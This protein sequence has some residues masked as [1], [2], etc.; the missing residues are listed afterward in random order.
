MEDKIATISNL[1]KSFNSNLSPALDNINASFSK[2]KIIGLIGP[3]GAGKTT[4]IRIMTGL[5][6]PTFGNVKILENDT[7]KDANKIY[8]LISYMPQKFGLYEDLTVQQNLELYANLFSL[9]ADEKKKQFEKL[10]HFTNLSQFT[11]RLAGKL[12]GGMKQ[13]LGLAC[14]LLRKPDLLLLDEPS[15]GVDPIS[16]KELWSM[17]SELLK[18]NIS[19]IWS[20]SYLDEAEKCSEVLVLNEGKMLYLGPPKDLTIKL[21]KRTFNITDISEDRREVQQKAFKKKD[22]IYSVIQGSSVRLVLQPDVK[23]FDIKD[24]NAGQNAKLNE[25]KPKFEDAFMDLLKDKITKKDSPL[26]TMFP[27]IERSSKPTIEVKNLVKKFKDFTAVNNI[28]F[29]VN[30]GKIFGL[31]GPNGAGK[32]TTFK[33]LCGL[34]KPTDGEAFISGLSLKKFQSKARAKLG[35]MAQKFSLY[36]NLTVRQNLNFF[37]G[38]YPIDEDKKKPLI[39]KIIEIFSL[40]AYVNTK[41]VSLPLGYKQRLALSCAIMHKPQILFLDEPTSGVDPLTRREFWSHINSMVKKGVS[42]IIT[43]HFMDEAEYCDTI[44]L[45]NKGTIIKIGSPDE[46]KALVATKENPFPS[47][48]DAFISLSMQNENREKENGK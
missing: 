24:L 29:S 4:L 46:L 48:E 26:S 5:L 28:S 1:T 36:E 37:S 11:L 45:I 15:V 33:M 3:D 32:S 47:L 38:I 34:L 7:L 20:T 19:V 31:L 13:K 21:Q 25:I 27:E 17:V 18:E 41:T 42:I 44:A 10:L 14:T 40:N 8:N 12:S 22:V 35:Y 9:N 16:R 23:N 2:G 43:T 39:E 6:T 30:N